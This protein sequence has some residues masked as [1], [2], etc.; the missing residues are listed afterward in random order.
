MAAMGSVFV[1]APGVSARDMAERFLAGMGVSAEEIANAQF[2]S[3]ATEEPG[4][5]IPRGT[6]YH[7]YEA[8]QGFPAWI[9]VGQL[10]EAYRARTLADYE[11]YPQINDALFGATHLIRLVYGY[12]ADSERRVAESVQGLASDHPVAWLDDAGAL[13]RP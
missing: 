11:G 9:R 10:D 3:A 7:G 2:R 13:H 12:N 5:A 1:S 8:E 6:D 4:F